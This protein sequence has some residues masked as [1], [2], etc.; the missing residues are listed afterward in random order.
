MKMLP[1]T[2]RFWA[3]NNAG[4]DIAFDPGGRIILQLQPWKLVSGEVVY[5]TEITDDFNFSAGESII[6]GGPPIVMATTVDNSSTKSWG[7]HGL[8]QVTIDDFGSAGSIDLYI[9][10]ADDSGTFPSELTTPAV[11]NIETQLTFVVS[12]PIASDA[13]DQVYAVNFEL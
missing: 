8:F 11:L 5:A 2:Y 6:E 4:E 3:F 13:V 12:I 7:T 10:S 1:E 9:E